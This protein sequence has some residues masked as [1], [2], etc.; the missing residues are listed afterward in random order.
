MLRGASAFSQNDIQNDFSCRSDAHP[1][2]VVLLH[3]LGPH[4]YQHMLGLYKYLKYYGYCTFAITYANYPGSPSLGGPKHINESAVEIAAFIGEVQSNTGASKVDLVGHSEGGFQALY[5][6]KFEGVAPLV[7]KV[8]AIAP[9]PRGISPTSLCKLV[10]GHCNL[11]GAIVDTDQDPFCSK[12]WNDLT[13]NGTAVRRLTDGQPIVQ[14][15]NQVTV[16][17]SRYDELIVP[18]ETAFVREPGVWN[19]YIQDFCEQDPV[20]H[21]LPAY[22]L[23]AWNIV[24]NALDAQHDRP[25]QCVVAVP[26]RS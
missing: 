18:P 4:W 3:G 6:P 20:G 5:V 17:I 13:T 25:F 7:D 21:V 8:V 12:A 10:T 1:N 23:N 15:G 16:L 2:P 11:T 9:P 19:V 26:L 14:P 22:D 24:R